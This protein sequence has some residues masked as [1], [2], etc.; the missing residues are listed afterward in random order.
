MKKKTVIVFLFIFIAFQIFADSFITL[1]KK[2]AWSTSY[3]GFVLNAYTSNFDFGGFTLG[4]GWLDIRNINDT[5]GRTRDFLV[6]TGMRQTIRLKKVDMYLGETVQ[7]SF[8]VYNVNSAGQQFWGS[9]D[10]GLHFPLTANVWLNMGL[11]AVL[12]L[13]N[14]PSWFYSYNY[15]LRIVL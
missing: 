2:E 9:I 3:T 12:H 1:G 6:S 14:F 5:D 10:T 11:G 15:G 13:N 7:M 8:S 4:V